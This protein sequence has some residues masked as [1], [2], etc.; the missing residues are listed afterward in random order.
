MVTKNLCQSCSMP[1]DEPGRMGTEK[2]GSKTNEYCAY[3][4]QNGAFVNPKMTL[5][6]MKI[7]VKTEMEKR[8]KD[9]GL[10]NTA[11]SSL[12]RLKRWATAMPQ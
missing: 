9:A 3:C 12:S 2:D 7:V 11:V 1:L 5:E 8:E 4:Y 6:E 10:I